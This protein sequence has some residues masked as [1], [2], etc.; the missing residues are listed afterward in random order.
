LKERT[1]QVTAILN[2]IK[3]G[4]Q[5]IIVGR[6]MSGY[7][8]IKLT[9]LLPVETLILMVPAAYS[10][11][12]YE[13]KFDSGFTEIIRK[14]KSWISSDAFDILSRFKGK[15]LV[16]GAEHDEVIPKEVLLKIFNAAQ[17]ASKKDIYI[18]QNSG[19]NIREFL[20]NN[21]LERKII[22]NKIIDLL[23]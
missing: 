8:A 15:L 12:A 17:N 10:K 21:E 7:T 5:L 14:E 4:H 6:S 16:I 23:F 22:Y 9:E 1:D 13:V 2:S 19:H 11:E 20:N 18:I 3:I